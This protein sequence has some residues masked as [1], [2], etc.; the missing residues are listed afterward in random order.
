MMRIIIF[1][2]ALALAGHTAQAQF[3]TT[4]PASKKAMVAEW[5]GLTKVK[6]EYHRP[7]VKGR[8]GEVYGEN[9]VVPYGASMPW[10][11][12]ADEN[13]TMY[14]EHDVTINGQPLAA[15]KYGFHILPTAGEWTLIFSKNNWSWGSYNY[16]QSEDALRVKAK[17]AD[18][19]ESVEWLEYRFV[20]QTDN[21]AD[22]ELRWEKKKVQFTVA[23]DVYAVTRASMEAEL[24]GML[25]FTWQGW[26][27]AA[28]YL[29][30]ADKDME[31]ALAWA[32]NAVNN[33]KNFSTLST[34]AQILE[35]LNR[36]ADAKTAMEEAVPLATMTELHFYARSLIQQEKPE[37]AMKIFRM[38]REKNPND[39]FTTLVGLARGNMALGNYKDA[40]NYFRKAAPNAPQ[41]QQE[42]Y[43]GLAKQCEEKMTKG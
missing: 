21:S 15:G 8:E 11:A 12:G 33:T 3:V 31:T 18:L 5:I 30:T 34:K 35:K 40:A 13:T 23:T 2:F 42:I 14:F 16:D 39:N 32:D 38:N 9:A 27:S 28:N 25:G 36:T 29:L 41:G 24:D 6:I 17:P 26:N 4:P 37:E 1:L 43:E 10:R 20:N 19:P 22:I 7:G